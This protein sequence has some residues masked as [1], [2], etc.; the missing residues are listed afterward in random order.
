M[1]FLI[2]DLK[3]Q[4]LLHPGHLRNIIIVWH[5][6]P[7]G[8]NCPVEEKYV[9][10][11]TPPSAHHCFIHVIAISVVHTMFLAQLGTMYILHLNLFQSF[12]IQCL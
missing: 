3:A 2:N 5:N 1:F 12:T 8:H 4:Q 11:I 6:G 7:V 10:Y 9:Q